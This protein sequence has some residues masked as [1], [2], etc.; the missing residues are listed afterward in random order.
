L[1][2]DAVLHANS[3]TS[4]VT[5]PLFVWSIVQLLALGLSAARVKF[6]AAFPATGETLALSELLVVQLIAS[7]LLFPFLCQTRQ[8]VIAILVASLPALGLAGYLAQ[9]SFTAVASTAGFL[10][11]WLIGLSGWREVVRTERTQLIAVSLA[12]TLTIGVA[13]MFYLAKESGTDASWLSR[14]NLLFESVRI[15][16]QPNFQ[17]FFVLSCIAI[18]GVA[19]GLVI[20]VKLSTGVIH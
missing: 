10:T 2:G 13:V 16:D 1:N 14:A 9:A 20:R 8:S 17:A 6:W 15:S 3:S 7:S 12:S 4:S 5:A 11:L 18:S 19:V